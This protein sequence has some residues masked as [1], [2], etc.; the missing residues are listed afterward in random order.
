MFERVIK[1]NISGIFL[2][3]NL[4]QGVGSLKDMAL[5]KLVGMRL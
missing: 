3:E 2:I 1:E 5:N 4:N